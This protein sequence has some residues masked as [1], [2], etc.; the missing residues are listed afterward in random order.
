[1][2]NDAAEI[3]FKIAEIAYGALFLAF[4]VFVVGSLVA[5]ALAMP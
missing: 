3:A 5:L 2:K 4:G 1:M